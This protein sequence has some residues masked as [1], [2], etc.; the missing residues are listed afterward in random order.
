MY[1]W[2]FVLFNYNV[3]LYELPAEYKVLIIIIIIMIHAFIAS[4]TIIH[5]I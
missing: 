5:V 3:S 1:Q 4:K 2:Q